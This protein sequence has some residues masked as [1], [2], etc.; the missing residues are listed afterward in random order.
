[1]RYRYKEIIPDKYLLKS[2]IYY[3]SFSGAGST[4]H[5]AGL[6]EILVSFIILSI[7]LLGL[8]ALQGKSHRVEIESY[9]RTQALLI[10]EDMAERLRIAGSIAA[11]SYITEVGYRSNFSDLESCGSTTAS[12]VKRDLSCWHKALDDGGDPDFVRKLVGGHGCI[13]SLGGSLYRV[14]VSWQGLTEIKQTTDDPRKTDL[15]GMGLYG[16]EPFRHT[17]SLTVGFYP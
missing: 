9:Q 13:T 3:V 8:T 7:G 12:M 1:M 5:G 10:A 14:S 17:V 4:Q 11:P 16:N 15:C 6:I 2:W